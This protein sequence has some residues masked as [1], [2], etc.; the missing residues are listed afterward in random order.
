MAGVVGEHRPLEPLGVV[1]FPGGEHAGAGHPEL[2]EAA[3][4]VPIYLE[5]PPDARSR[6]RKICVRGNQSGQH[7]EHE[8]RS[9]CVKRET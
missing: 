5:R 9:G 7:R 2:P 4:L 3:V 1:A 6:L 8:R